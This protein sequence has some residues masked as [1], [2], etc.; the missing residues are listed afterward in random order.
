MAG[1]IDGQIDRLMAGMVAG[2]LQ[3]SETGTAL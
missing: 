3:G 2:L 1:W